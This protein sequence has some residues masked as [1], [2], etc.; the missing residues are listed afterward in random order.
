MEKWSFCHTLAIEKT[1]IERKMEEK[2]KGRVLIIDDNEDILFA[3]NLLLKPLVEDIRVT[4]QH[5]QIDRFYDLLHPDV[6]LI[7]LDISL[8]GTVIISRYLHQEWTVNHY[9]PD[10]DCTYVL[11]E[12]NKDEPR[13][14]W[15]FDL[16]L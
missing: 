10:F 14:D 12:N 4:T 16:S 3:L 11:A 1:K 8:S 2:K 5:D 9:M 6:V 13:D 7:G 15:S